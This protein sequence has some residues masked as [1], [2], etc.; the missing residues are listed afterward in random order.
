M[1]PLPGAWL[2]PEVQRQ[3][4]VALLAREPVAHHHGRQVVHRVVHARVLPVD[5]AQALVAD[6]PVDRVRVVVA[7]HLRPLVEFHVVPNP[8][9]AAPQASEAP[10]GLALPR[11]GELE[12]AVALGEEIDRERAGGAALVE[13]A[14]LPHARREVRGVLVVEGPRRGHEARELPALG[15]DV[16]DGGVDAQ[17]HSRALGHH[18]GVAVDQ[19]GRA[20]AR[21][22][23]DVLLVPEVERER[24]V[25]QARV[26]RLDVGYLLGRAREKAA[27]VGDCGGAHVREH[28]VLAE[29]LH[30]VELEH[31]LGG[32]DGE[33]RQLVGMPAP[34]LLP[35]EALDAD[36]PALAVVEPEEPLRPLGRDVGRAHHAGARGGSAAEVRQPPVVADVRDQLARGVPLLAH[37]AHGAVPAAEAD[38]RV[39]RV[40]VVGAAQEGAA[41]AVANEVQAREVRL[42]CPAGA[43]HQVDAEPVFE[44]EEALLLVAHNH[45]DVLDARLAKLADLPLDE[46]LALVFEK[47]FGLVVKRREELGRFT[48][49]KDNR[50]FNPV[51]HWNFSSVCLSSPR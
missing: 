28:A 32:G 41:Q 49:G 30:A 20:H 8:A 23:V 15:A 11:G 47:P 21:V 22:P 35:Q 50:G 2:A 1:A 39:L 25:R 12:Q 34:E 36:V 6:D 43:H 13:R 3:D 18:L 38:E 51:A 29:L 17:L 31:A 24:D 37:H 16:D 10:H 33:E 7:E 14:D 45:G 40:P 5:H 9:Q 4:L 48:G 26:Q 46:H 27:D 44:V 42:V 19:G